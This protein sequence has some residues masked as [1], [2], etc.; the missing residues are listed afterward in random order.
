MVLAGHVKAHDE[1]AI[2]YGVRS[3]ASPASGVGVTA[4]PPPPPPSEL[5]A[6]SKRA[7]TA[8]NQ[9]GDGRTRTVSEAARDVR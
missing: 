5:H 3:G 4:P 2:V 7:P 9:T 8:P 6:A 1:G